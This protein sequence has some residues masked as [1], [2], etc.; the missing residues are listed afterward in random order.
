MV[1]M[2]LNMIK[3]FAIVTFITILIMEV[4]S[5]LYAVAVEDLTNTLILYAVTHFIPTPPF[6][7]RNCVQFLLCMHLHC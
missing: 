1:I 4:A 7:F 5:Y 3:I 6:F 2:K